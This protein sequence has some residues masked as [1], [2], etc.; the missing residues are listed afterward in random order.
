M[1]KKKILREIKILY[2]L[3]EG[4][5]VVKLLDI[6][7]DNVTKTPSLVFEHINNVDYKLIFPKIQEN[8][9]KYYMYELF[10]VIN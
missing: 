6:V 10:R 2:N 5:N 4:P 1:K 7:R 8:D 9:L 3:Q